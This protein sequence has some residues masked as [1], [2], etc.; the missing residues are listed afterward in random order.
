[1]RHQTT[2]EH[3][4]RSEWLHIEASGWSDY[5]GLYK[6]RVDGAFME[7]VNVI[8]LL[9]DEDIMEIEAAIPDAFST[10]AADRRVTGDIP[11]P[12]PSI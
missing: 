5:D 3:K 11:G 12:Y 6:V 4:I 9:T 7:G 2:F 1:M 8:G 10:D